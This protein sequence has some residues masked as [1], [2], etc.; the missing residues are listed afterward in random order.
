M[1]EWG[2]INTINIVNLLKSALFSHGLDP[3]AV[4]RHS[5]IWCVSLMWQHLMK[6]NFCV[7]AYVLSY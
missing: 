1:G 3:E 5:R 2:K 6:D 7:T 4:N